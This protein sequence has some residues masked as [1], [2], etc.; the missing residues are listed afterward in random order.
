[1]EKRLYR[2]ER[3]K[4]LAGVS[5]GLA[6]YFDMDVTWVRIIFVFAAV[7]GFSGVIIYV[8]LWIVVPPKPFNTGFSS[9][10][11]DYKV[12]DDKTSP[13]T[14]SGY[15][16]ETPQPPY[17]I[18]KQN[19]SNTRLIGGL[20]LVFF[21]AYFLLEEFDVFPYWFNLHRLW[22][23]IFIVLG[24]LIISRTEKKSPYPLP[25]EDVA[26]EKIKEEPP[27]TN[28]DQTP[29]GSGQSLTNDYEEQ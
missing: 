25:E 10:N 3:D 15:Q 24:V 18:K 2:N 6:E 8:I 5:S 11:T 14:G 23:V 26:K 7:F 13:Y 19:S 9:Y 12:Y 28:T 21:G 20:I 27:S 4:I 1:M 16:A 29:S 22:P 17:L